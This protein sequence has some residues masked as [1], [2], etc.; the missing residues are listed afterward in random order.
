MEIMIINNFVYMYIHIYIYKES[1]I[2]LKLS[3]Y[4]NLSNKINLN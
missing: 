1:K 3:K 2:I 4:I